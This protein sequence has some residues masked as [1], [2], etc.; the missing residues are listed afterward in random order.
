MRLVEDQDAAD[1]TADTFH[2]GHAL[3]LARFRLVLLVAILG[4]RTLDQ[5]RQVGTAAHALV[6]EKMQ[7][8]H[9]AQLERLAQ[10]HAQ[11]AGGIL[12]DALVEGDFLLVVVL[13]ITVKNTLA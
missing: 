7:L 3:L 12:E 11:V 1:R 4:H 5:R 13:A 8:R 10:Q 6:V 2:L 9:G